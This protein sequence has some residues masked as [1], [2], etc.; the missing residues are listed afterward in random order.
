MSFGLD[1]VDDASSYESVSST[2]KKFLQ[3]S[4]CHYFCMPEHLGVGTSSNFSEN[5]P[6]RWERTNYTFDAK[7][8][9][10]NLGQKIAGNHHFL[11]DKV[12]E[13]GRERVEKGLCQ[14]YLH[15]HL[16]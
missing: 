15:A 13:R 5:F 11:K 1:H 14:G 3:S 8:E 6:T 7:E 12:H 9:T 4:E 2:M 16:R 10:T